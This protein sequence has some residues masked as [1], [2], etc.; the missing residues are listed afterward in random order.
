VKKGGGGDAGTYGCAWLITLLGREGLKREGNN[1]RTWT[2]II[3]KKIKENL[4]REQQ[5]HRSE[6]PNHTPDFQGKIKKLGQRDE[7]KYL[8]T[9][10]RKGTGKKEKH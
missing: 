7:E 9:G 1:P 8:G 2:K 10:P 6:E 4:K 5:K 3:Y